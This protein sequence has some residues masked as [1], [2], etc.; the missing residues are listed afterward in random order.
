MDVVVA[1]GPDVQADAFAQRARQLPNV[2]PGAAVDGWREFVG[3][4]Q[5]GEVG[6]R[7]VTARGYAAG[8][9]RK[10]LAGR[11][12]VQCAL[13]VAHL[14]WLLDHGRQLCDLAAAR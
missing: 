3:Q 8:V 2:N 9:Q 6:R 13:H 5:G 7:H 4:D 14:E 12:L 1:E 11:C 10:R